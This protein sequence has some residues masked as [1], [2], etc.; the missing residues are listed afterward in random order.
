M[1]IT[2]TPKRLAPAAPE[3]L[4]LQ[5]R[6]SHSSD[7]ELPP[8]LDSISE[9][10]W[11]RGDLYYWTGV[12]NRF[13]H[14][15]EAICRDYELASIQMNDFTPLT[16]RLAVSVL[17]FSR[18][19]LEN[20]TNRKLYNSFEHLSNLLC[21]RD[22]DVL[23][24][25]LRLVLRIAQQHNS[26][27]TK[28]DFQVSKDR[29]TT[30]AMIWT[31]RDH[32]VSL[33]D[34]ARSDAALPAELGQVRFQ[35][36]KRTGR[37]VAP[38][39]RPGSAATVAV[40]SSSAAPSNQASRLDVAGEGEQR[41]SHSNNHHHHN[42][43]HQHHHQR[44]ATHGHQHP[45]H[46]P[47]TATPTRPRNREG[48]PG[49]LPASSTGTLPSTPV[50]GSDRFEPTTLL[51]NSNAAGGIAG[52][53]AVTT[54]RE[55]LV[56]VDLARLDAAGKD[57]AD[58]L[59]EA[60]ETY[61]IPPEE[62]FELFQRIRLAIC[63]PQPE[64]R[65]QL[66]VCRLLAVACYGLVIS[67][68]VANTQIFLY[69]PDLV[70]RVAA[71]ID[72]VQKV[73]MSIQ[74][75]AF[76][77]LDSLGRYRNK[78]SL[79]LNSV[80]ASVNHGIILSVL[81][82]LIEDLRSQS[83]VSTDHYVDS[84]LSF[85]AFICSGSLGS[86]M[87]V[88]AGLIP[89]LIELV[90]IRN[91]DR[92]MVQRTVSRALGLV[93]SLAFA[94]PQAFD[95][96]CNA[97][98]LDVLVDRIQDEVDRDIDDG[99]HDRMKHSRYGEPGPDNLYGKLAF[100]RSSLLRAM[101]KSITQMMS[102]TGTG[103][104]LR[105]LINT[106]LP[107]SLKKIIE[108]RTIFGPQILALTINIMA[109]FIHNEPTSLGIL[110]EAKMPEAFF[111][112]IESDVE[113]NFDVILAIPNAVGAICLNQA[114]LDLFNSR[115]VILKLFSLFTSERHSKVLQD[116]DNAS[117]FGA[118]IDELV[119][120]QPSIKTSVIN[121]VMSCLDDIHSNGK[122]FAPPEDP[123]SRGAYGL[124]PIGDALPLTMTD[125]TVASGSD[126][127][128][129]PPAIGAVAL[130][131]VVTDEP[132]PIKKD[133]SKLETNAVVVSID[134]IARFLEGLFQTTSH[135]KDFLK[136]DGLY[137]LLG[138]YSLPCLTYDF[139][140]SPTA[141]S[142]VTLIRFMAEISPTTVLVAMLRDI[143]LVAEVAAPIFGLPA[144]SFADFLFE[145]ARS[146]LLE[147]SSPRDE[148][149]AAA[150]NETFQKLVGLCS[151]C[152]LLSDICQMFTYAGQKMPSTFLQTIIASD[153]SPTISIAELG[154]IHRACAWENMLLKASLPPPPPR[155]KGKDVSD[156]GRAN[157]SGARSANSSNPD[158]SHSGD[159]SAAHD[160]NAI[161]ADALVRSES[162]DTLPDAR[163]DAP[164]PAQPG[165]PDDLLLDVAGTVEQQPQPRTLSHDGEDTGVDIEHDPRHR[166]AAALR[167]VASQIPS[168]LTSL[169]QETVRFLS[170]RRGVDA[171]HRKAAQTASTEIAQVLK[172]HLTWRQSSNETNSFAFATM[173]ICQA[174]C[175]LF[176]DRSSPSPVQTAVLRGLDKL[177]GL[178]SL[179]D[180][181]RRYTAEIDHFYNADGSRK[182]SIVA[183]LG[184]AGLKLGHT[185]GGLKV[186]LGV[187]LKLVTAKGL[188]DSNQTSQLIKEGGLDVF[189]PGAYLAKIRAA[190][191][192]ELQVTWEKPWLPSLPASV[193][194]L[195]LQNLLEILRALNEFSI[196]PKKPGASGS[197]SG[198]AA[199]AGVGGLPALT[200]M[201]G[202]LTGLRNPFAFGSAPREMPIRRTPNEDRVTQLVDMGFP[203]NAARLALSRCHNDLSAATEY[204]LTH[205][206][207]VNQFR[208]D[209]NRPWDDS[210]V[211]NVNA[212]TNA[213]T[214]AGP[215]HSEA[216]PG[217]AAAAAASEADASQGNA[218]N[219][220]ATAGEEAM[221]R[222]AQTDDHP[223]ADAGDNEATE[224]GQ[225]ADETLDAE[226][227]KKLK[228]D[229]ASRRYAVR[230]NLVTRALELADHHPSLVFEV[231]DCLLLDKWSRLSVSEHMQSI[232]ITLQGLGEEAVGVKADFVALRL[233]L[234]ALVLRNE[235]LFKSLEDSTA[236]SIMDALRSLI[237]LYNCRPSQPTTATAA[238]TSS[239]TTATV[240]AAQ[241]KWLASL[242][243]VLVAILGF[244]ED[245]A[246]A[247]V[248]EDILKDSPTPSH[249]SSTEETML[250]QQQEEQK[251]VGEEAHQPLQQE[252]QE[253]PEASSL[254]PPTPLP[255]IRTR[256]I[257]VTDELYA[258][259]LQVL[260]EALQL[261]RNDLLAA[262]RLLSVLT[263]NHS[264]AAR[265]VKDGGVTLL[266]EPF[267]VLEPRLVSG[268]QPFV[269][270][271][272][273]HII[274]DAETLA[275]V[276]QQEI[277]SFLAQSRGKASDTTSLV[278]Q[279]DSAVLRDPDVFVESA[280]A[281]VEMTDYS[282]A[283]TSGHIKL[284]E[285][286]SSSSDA[287][288][289]SKAGKEGSSS[290]DLAGN[291]Q[292]SLASLR[293]GDEPI[294]AAT[295][296]N[297]TNVDDGS[298]FRAAT[299]L[300]AAPVSQELDGLM[301]FLITE[302]LQ[303]VRDAKASSTDSVVGSDDPSA[304]TSGSSSVPVD[305]GAAADD[306]SP[307]AN[308]NTSSN[309]EAS[310]PLTDAQKRKDINF[311]YSCFLMQC[312]TELLSSYSSCKTSFINFNKRRLFASINA[313]GGVPTTPGPA[314]TTAAAGP[315]AALS[316]ERGPLTPGG[317]R[318]TSRAKL[319][320]LSTFLN[321]LV[322][323]GFLSSFES[324]ELRRK[325]AQSNWAMSVVVALTADVAIHSDLKEVPSDLANVRKVVLDAIS[326]AI[327]EA[328]ASSE[329]IEVRYGRLF[330]LSDLCWRLLI[331]RPNTTGAKQTEDLTLHM[332]KTMLEKNFVTVLTS[333][334]AD[335]D[336][337][338][339]TVKTL[340]EAI[341]K[342]LE[343]LTKVA[344]KMGKA[345][346]RQ[347]G[348]ATLD[349][350]AEE[351]SL[352]SDYDMDDEFDDD[353]DE[354]DDDHHHHHHHHD[355]EHGP[356]REETPD[357]Y[358]NSSLGMHTGEMEQGFDDDEMTDEEM[359]DEEDIDMEE[360]D[361]ETGSELSSD[362][363]TDMSGSDGDEPAV[364]E[365]DT[366]SDLLGS[367][368]DGW[369][370]E[371]DENED[372][373]GGRR[374]GR[375]G[376]GSLVD[377]GEEHDE[378][379]SGDEDD[380]DDE[381]EAL[382][383]VFEDDEGGLPAMLRDGFE[384]ELD[385]TGAID[386]G[387]PLDPQLEDDEGD[388][389]DDD[390][391]I[392]DGLENEELSQLELAE[393]YAT[394]FNQADDRFGA[395]WG[396][397]LVP[398]G[399]AGSGAGSRGGDRPRSGGMLPPNF[400]LPNA[401]EN[402]TSG[403]GGYRRR[404]LLDIES[405]MAPRRGTAQADEVA[406]H[407]LLVDRSEADG[408]PASGRAGRRGSSAQLPA[409]LSNWAQS[410]EDIVGDGALQFLETLL[411]RGGQNRDIHIELGQNGRMR[412]D[413]IEMNRGGPHHHQHHHHLHS[414]HGTGPQGQGRR[415]SS[416]A[417]KT[418][419]VALA[420][421][422]TPQPT[423]ARWAEEA[424]I[425][426]PSSNTSNSRTKKVQTHL[427]NALL[428]GLR[429][430]RLAWWDKA[431]RDR[432]RIKTKKAAQADAEK[433]LDREEA[434]NELARVRA[435]KERT[436]QELAEARSRLQAAEEL[437]TQAVAG[438]SD[439][440]AP[441]TGAAAGTVGAPAAPVPEPQ[442]QL[443][444]DISAGGV[445]SANASATSHETS[446]EASAAAAAV[447]A[448]SEDIEMADAERPTTVS[449]APAASNS[450]DT[451]AAASTTTAE[452]ANA[453]DESAQSTRITTTIHGEEIDITDTG[454]DPTFL[455]ALPDEL[456]EEVVNQHFRER[457]AAQ[458]TRNLPQP[459]SIAP[460]FLEALPAELR[461]EVIQQEAIENSRRRL[462]EQ[463]AARSNVGTPQLT[464]PS[465]GSG[466]AAANDA[467]SA[468]GGEARGRN[469]MPTD[470]L[471]QL[472]EQD[473]EFFNSL[474]EN[475]LAEVNDLRRRH[476]RFD[477]DG[478]EES[479]DTSAG[480][481]R[482]HPV[483]ESGAAG[484]RPGPT[485]TA[486]AQGG[487][488]A[489][490]TE[491]EAAKK[492]GPRDAIQLLDKSG[493]ATLVRLLFFPQ[494][495]ARQTALH[496]VLANLSENA[497]TRSELLNLLLMVL[498]EGS[499]D[500]HAVDRSFVTMSNRANRMHAT[501]SRPT[502]R[503]SNSMSA[504]A[505]HAQGHN[506]MSGSA[507]GAAGSVA[508][509]SRTG[510]EAPFLIASRS[511]ETLVHL[512]SSNQQAA[513]Y[514]LRDDSR[515]PRRPKGK[516]KEKEKEIQRAT[517]P[518]NVL[519]A[520]LAKDT[521]LANSQ[522]VDSLLS[523]LSTITKPLLSLPKVSSASLR[524]GHSSSDGSATLSEQR[525]QSARLSSNN[526]DT[527][528]GAGP[529]GGAEAS[530]SSGTT[531]QAEPMMTDGAVAAA[532]MDAA[533]DSAQRT[534][535]GDGALTTV[536]WIPADRL[537]A[538]VRPLATA[539]SS[540]GFQNTL[541]VASHLSAIDGA[542]DIICAA[543][544]A[545]ADRASK[546]LVVDL[547][548]LLS[549]LPEPVEEDEH[550]DTPA[551]D[552]HNEGDDAAVTARA[553]GNGGSDVSGAGAG[554]SGIVIQGPTVTDGLSTHGTAR[555]IES[556]ALAGLAS[557]SSAQAVLLR[558]LRALDYIMTG[559]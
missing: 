495:N 301:G 101:F 82:A 333:A 39:P 461:A 4:A 296:A 235:H 44:H 185:C 479:Q 433:D 530:A 448:S 37:S 466:S 64:A 334:I 45:G 103:E 483:G 179:F 160:T 294:D 219:N 410:I 445:R 141:D 470:L 114:G 156:S 98:G 250:Q 510:D 47:D 233:Q 124:L 109:T 87:I 384:G 328:A 222:S 21:T 532:A 117:M 276:M 540:R 390:E 167:Y 256:A 490:D 125:A 538:I 365:I 403:T 320:I 189:D 432:R 443:P 196:T 211:S 331:A 202:G 116:R 26:H 76:Y 118:A 393:D 417:T 153:T 48:R 191:L 535:S 372:D 316:S 342:P 188:T 107:S 237:Q 18:L 247:T 206:E 335:V 102:S 142:L 471:E 194:R 97:R 354:D 70:Q 224:S 411:A 527:T 475:M 161:S 55:G 12:L 414:Q 310:Q 321:D 261:E 313:S 16:K 57:M 123:R 263:R 245:N 426:L 337:N 165:V 491:G 150:A 207:V 204:L 341:L 351:S 391:S 130:A 339:P 513:L 246:T 90:R 281:K 522:L 547:D 17:R 214:D 552:R 63:L 175:L 92:Y 145:N 554:A 314:L 344:I 216:E 366:D 275:S 81:R 394:A 362:E 10:C 352:S 13:D 361:S 154:A 378:D 136:L 498:S 360:Y 41:Q 497:K 282:T 289:S 236:T 270:L 89:L 326:K 84:V 100:G 441:S 541:A 379:V 371:D 456:R 78:I 291:G 459:T 556:E 401:L 106:S 514:F 186:V 537:S 489:G 386:D 77:A 42:H 478:D 523:L 50:R 290:S 177:G 122:N 485:S 22:L 152:H 174:S 217:P 343:R 40:A 468:A 484:S 198:S 374:R 347:A 115:P 550:D 104:G 38:G 460:E 239:V 308:T 56:T 519:L 545:Q 512:T 412:I 363:D 499:V 3:V 409:G 7:D 465:S 369:T 199:A 203:A 340:L 480:T 85:V 300:P 285:E 319:G 356:G 11:P 1:K 558:S 329:P 559:R 181:Y 488:G 557:P 509:L 36:F 121:S 163:M 213:A 287:D 392:D 387:L 20:C 548:A 2:K 209:P 65:H 265:F 74:S 134:V 295:G 108:Y 458:A 271:V 503:R 162:D 197:S 382:D 258:F 435:D 383:F 83:P 421:A 131:D 312:L 24:A 133:H 376:P 500:A 279:L 422:F 396:W 151:R 259:A 524:D 69:E 481:T 61:E 155:S 72:P 306:E 349:E 373:D 93:D 431:L 267:K 397:T 192:A 536:P 54:R 201:L 137:K 80:S 486:A 381:D 5:H 516:E 429:K 476:R 423:I 346:D 149:E 544:Q 166:N 96:F 232:L 533:Q 113:A 449:S 406:N 268:C 395:N 75:S 367:D 370:D 407:P 173:M 345:K 14:I 288:S 212:N 46:Q 215:E 297:D 248:N 184:E 66:L 506:Q 454:I 159:R 323:A 408:R 542:R 240:P 94:V 494:M 357:F 180:L 86:H 428:P 229:L 528:S 128:A 283:K 425:L 272:L 364:I 330:A 59:T 143:K 467:T 52:V 427:I 193:N 129:A 434:E 264:Y 457:R 71:L 262:Y 303:I 315:F 368:E 277:H 126:S 418:D 273:R 492:A 322:P 404:Q 543:L 205:D 15:L 32:G 318:D 170:P 140:V 526:N 284:I 555:R 416:D 298:F 148:I 280:L 546:S 415:S 299:A 402:A 223:M 515:P 450:T 242:L 27:A 453:P 469:E 238:G 6:I 447:D 34:V 464:G 234:V 58:V 286:E 278:R 525:E 462:R 30:L 266:F 444:Q 164:R 487:G 176:D 359:E 182:E 253:Q 62:R 227:M 496:K 518:V 511:I 355:H 144:T 200:T 438:T 309:A 551:G 517:A 493:V 171:A 388:M 195:M 350:S 25:V 327:R 405:M 413:G 269:V 455:E 79:V 33:V 53:G 241:P 380:D 549:S 451:S 399:A 302:L 389:M 146:R 375:R 534:L 19:L 477:D 440:S 110:Q 474:P 336:L 218:H 105:N 251:Q 252:G 68:S 507:V 119:R 553:R 147:L 9:W 23:E 332:A 430:R 324:A 442:P 67:E 31:P 88:G 49:M 226:K 473:E 502:P 73:D 452:P 178:E 504:S 325:M 28:H 29:L 304:P 520:L 210:P 482:V 424:L 230:A 437:Q 436:E 127:V 228:S 43:H 274:E 249:D 139:S 99:S 120:H 244:S 158:A 243:L 157:D 439:A 531:D 305:A 505:V 398:D 419:P 317:A 138:L 385:D 501:P 95:L 311:F 169:F 463:L 111:N 529:A 400:F 377:D 353:D 60:I 420:Q 293:L 35:F 51:S 358:R 521:I 8:V 208:D 260:R 255:R 190:V 112:C 348:K 472:M 168:S 338:L 446:H 132:D 220:N 307:E 225:P 183:D 292:T 508:P 172:E 221:Q 187:L 135:C 231:K 254:P 539:I 257:D 91:P